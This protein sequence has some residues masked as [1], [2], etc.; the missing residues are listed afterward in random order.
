MFLLN[1]TTRKTITTFLT[2]LVFVLVPRVAFAQIDCDLHSTSFTNANTGS[3]IVVPMPSQIICPFLR[4][5]NLALML[6]GVALAVFIGFGA[7]KLSVSLG[8]PKGYE[9]SMRTF[10]F[11][12]IGF[13]VVVGSFSLLF[14]LNRTLGL[15]LGYGSADSIGEAVF[16]WWRTFL[17]GFLNLSET[18]SI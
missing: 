17:Q 1:K 18:A 16:N 14:M 10:L 5:I 11:A 15:G 4:L 12:I 7:I 6:S 3:D 9:G 8:D 13:F 2:V